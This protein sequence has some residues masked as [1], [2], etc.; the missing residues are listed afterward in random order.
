MAAE[1]PVKRRD[2][3]SAA[4]KV[5]KMV[6]QVPY[7]PKSTR[8][9]GN[10][11]L[12]DNASTTT[13]VP[14]PSGPQSHCARHKFPS[15]VSRFFPRQKKGSALLDANW[16]AI[17]TP[18]FLLN[19]V[20]DSVIWTSCHAL[21]P[22]AA[23]GMLARKRDGEAGLCRGQRWEPHLASSQLSRIWWKQFDPLTQVG[24]PG[25]VGRSTPFIAETSHQWSPPQ[26]GQFML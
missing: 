18:A 16:K 22:L 4:T 25:T 2:A 20:A 14:L 5:L 1:G 3:T 9:D 15:P 7:A 12:S 26:E 21:F 17:A 8:R 11:L 6:T 10:Q 13:K 24:Q 19:K 23:L